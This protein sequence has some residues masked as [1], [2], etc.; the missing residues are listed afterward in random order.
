MARSQNARDDSE[1]VL[2]AFV[3]IYDVSPGECMLVSPGAK[4]DAA[5]EHD[6]VTWNPGRGFHF[7]VR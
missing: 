4:T 7:V 3:T 1:H 2:A 6:E 5:H